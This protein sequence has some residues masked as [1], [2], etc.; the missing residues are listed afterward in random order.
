V[1]G[2]ANGLEAASPALAVAEG[3]AG[4]AA[5]AGLVIITAAVVS[6]KVRSISYPSLWAFLVLLA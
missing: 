5:V 2:F 1:L 3:L 4:V 6:R